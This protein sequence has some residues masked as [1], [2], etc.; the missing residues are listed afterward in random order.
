MEIRYS[1]LF[2][3]HN[4][5]PMATIG[6]FDRDDNVREYIKTIVDEL[7]NNAVNRQYIFD[8]VRETTKNNMTSIITKI[9]VLCSL[10]NPDERAVQLENELGDF[11]QTQPAQRLSQIEKDFNDN[12][13]QLNEIPKGVLIVAEISDENRIN[14]LLLAKADYAEFMEEQ[15]GDM[16]LGLPTKKKIYKAVSIP[17]SYDNELRTY[18]LGCVTVCD[19]SNRDAKY[20]W[21]DFLELKELRS[22]EANTKKAYE[23]IKRKIILPIKDAHKADFVCLYNF[24]LAYFSTNSRFDIEDYITQLQTYQPIDDTLSLNGKVEKL[25]TLPETAHFDRTFDKAPHIITDRMKRQTIKLANNLDLSIKGEIENIRN[26]ITADQDDQGCKR[27]TILSD[28]GYDYFI[29]NN[30]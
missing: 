9:N 1:K 29:R 27:I 15:S 26:T 2:I 14:Q 30:Q 19:T 8:D 4:D 17:Y 5:V 16:K 3:I 18:I 22:N 20:W 12:H 23:E 21:K 24:N 11:I 10:D 25:R 7:L 13:P 28:D 6:A